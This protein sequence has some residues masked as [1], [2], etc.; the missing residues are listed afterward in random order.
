MGGWLLCNVWT[1]GKNH[2]RMFRLF[3]LL[4]RTYYSLL[5]KFKDTHI[6]IASN[7]IAQTGVCPFHEFHGAYN[8]T[9]NRCSLRIPSPSRPC[10][11]HLAHTTGPRLCASKFCPINN[12]TVKGE[13]N[14]LFGDR[15]SKYRVPTDML[16]SSTLEPPILERWTLVVEW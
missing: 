4:G 3:K 15:N 9:W 2:V 14:E 6:S 13:I 12:M 8:F 1:S 16:T 7:S 5:F 11:C 10:C